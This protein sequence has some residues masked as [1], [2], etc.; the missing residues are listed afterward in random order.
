[1]LKLDPWT[2]FWTV[3]NV[4]IMFFAFKKFLLKPV[5][6]I[7]EKRDAMIKEQF[8]SANQ[9]NEQ[10][11]LLKKEYEQQ[12]ENAHETAAE[13]IT[14]ARARAEEEHNQVLAQTGK[15]TKKMLDQAKAD[16]QHEQ[17]KAR[18]E[19]QAQIADI[20]MLATRKIIKT[21][22]MHDTGSN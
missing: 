8:A 7:I 5:M 12:L 19:L 3:F 4:M 15:E 10:A 9:T 21:G 6:D 11:A 20:A 13:I 17:D 18:L 16:I 1:M 2:L 14:N 22:E